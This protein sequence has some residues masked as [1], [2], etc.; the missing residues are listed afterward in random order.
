MEKQR[1]IELMGLSLFVIGL[2]GILLFFYMAYMLFTGSAVVG[3]L[4]GTGSADMTADF[5]AYILQ[6][7]TPILFL[8]VVGVVSILVAHYGI[9]TYGRV[10][11]KEP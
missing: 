9:S 10:Y 8:L 6:L 4:R 3:G 2:G 5:F 11:R 7:T 1:C